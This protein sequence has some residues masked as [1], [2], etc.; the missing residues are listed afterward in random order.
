MHI[1]YGPYEHNINY[2]VNVALIFLLLYIQYYHT[3]KFETV[4]KERM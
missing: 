2:V 4:A 3:S 1:V